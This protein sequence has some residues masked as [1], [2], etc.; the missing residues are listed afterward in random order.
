VVFAYPRK[1]IKIPI[2]VNASINEPLPAHDQ[3]VEWPNLI[4]QLFIAYL[5]TPLI[6][7]TVETHLLQ[8]FP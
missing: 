3:F 5:T 8:V 1:P 2:L 4:N 7:S 6:P